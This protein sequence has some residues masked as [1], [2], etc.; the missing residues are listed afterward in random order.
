MSDDELFEQATLT[1]CSSF[2]FSVALE[3]CYQFLKSQFPLDGLYV[4]FVQESEGVMQV[5]AMVSDSLGV[6]HELLVPLTG[7]AM[8][9]VELERLRVE[10]YRGTRRLWASD[11]AIGLVMAPVLGFTGRHLVVQFLNLEGS[12]VATLVAIAVPGAQFSAEDERRFALLNEPF[13]IAVKNSLSYQGLVRFKERLLEDNAELKQQLGRG[14]EL[15]CCESLPGLCQ[16]ATQ[17][18]QVATSSSTVLLLGETGV[19]KEVVANSLHQSSLRRNSPLIK[20]NCGA[21]AKELIDSELFG[22]EKGAFSGATA[23]KKGVFERADG[24]TIFLDE[25][26]ELPLPAQVRLLRVLQEREIERVGGEKTIPVD[27]RIIAATHCDLKEMVAQGQFREDLWFR[28]NVFPIEIPPLRQRKEDIPILLQ[29]FL[30][31]KSAQFGI[32]KPP[33][34]A[35]GALS[36]LTNYDWPGNVRELENTV[37]R[38]LIQNQG[39]LMRQDPFALGTKKGVENGASCRCVF[40]CISGRVSVEEAEPPALLP[41]DEQIAKHI[42]LALVESQGKIHGPGGAAELL[43]MN[44]NTLRSKMRKL[45]IAFH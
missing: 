26:G 8:A 15:S 12:Y 17:V 36:V 42:S 23:L 43:E 3:R 41:L 18:K 11:N 25:I 29:H 45:G 5:L 30:R 44:P 34:I 33:E 19:G 28:L 38:A 24:G 20:V 10:G 22:H 7:D 13:S 39:R 9:L 32:R 40:P 14:S 27:L 16:V 31:Q 1:I 4:D 2:D 37:E 35:P 21:I 6:Q